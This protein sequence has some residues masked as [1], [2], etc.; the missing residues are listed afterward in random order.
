MAPLLLLGILAC[1][2]S[3]DVPD[4]RPNPDTGTE[5]SIPEAPNVLVLLADDVGLDVVSAYE[6][7]PDPPDL[8][9]IDSLAADGVRFDNAWAY[10]ICSP[11]RAAILTG[12][13]GRRNG[14]GNTINAATSSKELRNT[15]VIIPRM[16]ELSDHDYSSIATGKWHLAAYASFDNITHP[17]LMGFDHFD[18]NMGNLNEAGPLQNDGVTERGYYRYEKNSDGVLSWSDTYTTTET[19]DDT[20]RRIDSMKEP[21]F[22]YVAFHAPHTPLHT[23]P[24]ELTDG[25]EPVSIG[26]TYRAMTRAMDTEIGR[27]LDS[28]DPEVRARTVIVFAGDNGTSEHG[29]IAPFRDSHAKNSPYEGGVN[30][31]LIVTGPGVVGKGRSEDALVHVLDI[32]ATVAE[33]AG[34]D[35]SEVKDPDG[36]QVPIDSV[37]LVPYLVQADAPH[38]RQFL[39][40]ENLY[41]NGRPPYLTEWNILRDERYKLII[42]HKQGGELFDLVGDPH[43]EDGNENLNLLGEGNP[44]PLT[45]EQQEAYDRLMAEMDRFLAEAVY[46]ERVE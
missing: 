5:T 11:T 21:W 25:A 37:S 4:K 33:L 26:E 23:P 29:T 28:L 9:V 45:A 27:L 32:Y 14:V 24:L 18:G 1:G 13:Y 42:G 36:L 34:V 30:V 15:E 20:I 17:Q 46:E 19:V 44:D 8:P 7:H 12:R 41:P 40:T 10:P 16:L 2:S 31:P 6:R 35:L 38:E 43:P 22:A 39:Y 3:K